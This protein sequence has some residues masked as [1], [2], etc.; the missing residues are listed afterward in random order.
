MR[1]WYRGEPGSIPINGSSDITDSDLMKLTANDT[2]QKLVIRFNG[3]IC[4]WILKILFLASIIMLFMWSINR[5]MII[6]EQSLKCDCDKTKLKPNEFYKNRSTQSQ[7][8]VLIISEARSGSSF[9]GSYSHSWF[10]NLFNLIIL[11]LFTR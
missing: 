9:L 10:Y 8:H 4:R 2:M 3:A 5:E 11:K 6:H 1:L 7:T